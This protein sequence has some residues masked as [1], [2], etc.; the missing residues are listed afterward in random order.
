MKR[1][2]NARTRVGS[3]SLAAGL[4]HLAVVGCLLAAGLAGCG[5]SGDGPAAQSDAT[6]AGVGSDGIGDDTSSDTSTEPDAV[7]TDTAASDTV[8][9]D[10]ADPDTVSQDTGGTDTAETDTA[11]TDVASSDAEDAAGDDASVD[12]G[13]PILERPMQLTHTCTETLPPTQP[14]PGD[15]TPGGLALDS[16]GAAWVARAGAALGVSTIA[17]DGTLGPLVELDTDQFTVGRTEM[18]VQG[19]RTIIVWGE[20]LP[21]GDSTLSYAAVEDGN[22]VV[23]AKNI[24]GTTSYFIHSV[25][26]ALAP[27]GEVGVLWADSSIQGKLQMRF[28][29]ID[30]QGDLTGDPIEIGKVASVTGSSEGVLVTTPTGFAVAWT[31]SVGLGRSE[32]WF[33]TIDGDGQYLISPKRISRES[34]QGYRASIG[35]RRGSTPLVVEGDG[36]LLAYGLEYFN[37]DYANPKG[38]T[39]VELAAIDSEGSEVIHQLH[40]PVNDVSSSYPTLFRLDGRLGLLWSSGAAI[41]IC[42]GCFVDNDLKLVLLDPDDLAPASEVATHA[43]A[44]HGYVQP[45]AVVLG[46]D[47]LS[48]SSQDFHAL[49]YP[50]AAV[51]H[52]APAP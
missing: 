41:Y 1:I 33:A 40:A 15:W 49:S 11:G 31:A 10:A 34:E 22:V 14:D 50:A 52:C 29:R 32:V 21:N 48:V 44:E 5:D 23:Q 8:S 24:A 16:D 27:D 4:R 35:Y 28:A 6:D 46:Q 38:W 45:A 42:A 36:Y 2:E 18:V 43:H 19:G 37:E 26:L 25:S 20:S 17:V 39:I 30:G 47:V 13:T 3:D 7:P 51:M 9:T 12:P